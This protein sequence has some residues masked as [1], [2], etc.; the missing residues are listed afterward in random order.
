MN[1]SYL[2][3]FA[4]AVIVT[5]ILILMPEKNNGKI[6]LTPER[7]KAELN[8]SSRFFTCDQVADRIIQGDPSFRLIDVRS[9]EEYNKYALPGA[10]NIPLDSM[11]SENWI[12]YLDPVGASNI[13]YSNGTVKS[14]EAWILCR[15]QGFKNNYVMYGGLNEWFTCIINPVAPSLISSN[16]EFDLYRFRKAASFY[17]MGGST[18]ETSAPA[19]MPAVGSKK[20]KEVQGGC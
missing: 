6:E 16:A 19:A 4:F 2:A 13:F 15:R 1:K 12:M 8:E 11:L 9:E 10:I 18:T 17:F 20:K 5:T 3:L 14:D 7:I